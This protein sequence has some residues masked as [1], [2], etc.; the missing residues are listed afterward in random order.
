[1]PSEIQPAKVLPPKSHNG[2]TEAMHHFF[3]FPEKEFF[4]GF[5]CYAN[6]HF[7]QLGKKAAALSRTDLSYIGERDGSLISTAGITQRRLFKE[8]M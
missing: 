4:A 7:F 5:Y 1:M 3:F 2:V 8:K 6:A